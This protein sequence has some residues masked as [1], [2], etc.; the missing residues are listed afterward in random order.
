MRAM[1]DGRTTDEASVTSS[2]D[3]T[4]GELQTSLVDPVEKL[5][6]PLFVLFDFFELDRQNLEGI[7][8][9]YV[10]GRVI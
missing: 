1:R 6:N 2:I 7:V 3:C 9:A 5:I 8:N 4:V 10:D